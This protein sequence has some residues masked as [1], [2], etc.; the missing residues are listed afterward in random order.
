MK[1]KLLTGILGLVGALSAQAVVIYSS[2]TSPP[3]SSAWGTYFTGTPSD[4]NATP[5]Y[6]YFYDGY[7]A[8]GTG[9]GSLTVGQQYQ[10]DV[11]WSANPGHNTTA[12]VMLELNDTNAVD[13]AY[14]DYM[15]TIDQSK[16]ADGSAPTAPPQWSGW[17]NIGTFTASHTAAAFAWDFTAGNAGPNTTGTIRLT[18][19]PEPAATTLLAGAMGI[20]GLR[21]RR[22]A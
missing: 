18:S 3:S 5:N 16:L 11:S 19:I 14:W 12:T 1:I 22:N 21:R 8:W 7:I 4:P 13:S 17:K 15:F 20:L 2:P 9:A 6:Y 10:V